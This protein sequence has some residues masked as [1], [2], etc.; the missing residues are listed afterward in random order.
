M[1]TEYPV[2]IDP[3]QRVLSIDGGPVRVK[4][5]VFDLLAF[6]AAHPDTLLTRDR[7]L[8]EVW[9]GT[10]VSD[11]SV[12][13]AVRSLRDVLGDDAA[14]PRYIETVRGH[15]YRF[16]GG[17]TIIEGQPPPAGARRRTSPRA[18]AAVLALAAIAAIAA[19]A[20]PWRGSPDFP[21]AS[22][23]AMPH[24]LPD[25]PSVAVLSF[26]PLAPDDRSALFAQGLSEDLTTSLAK[27][28]R[29]FVSARAASGQPDLAEMPPNRI[30][31]VLGVRY[32]LRGSV[33]ADAGTVRVSAQLI[34]AL[35]GQFVWTERYDGPAGDFLS[36]QDD[37]ALKV[38][39]S[40]QLELDPGESFRNTSDTSDLESWLASTE[41]YGA[42]LRFEQVS[43]AR[44]R[45]LWS[46]ALEHDPGR[47]VPHAGIAFTHYHDAWR[48]WSGDR[49][50]SI[51]QGLHHAKIA[52]ARAPDHPLGYQALGSLLVLTGDKEEGIALRRRAVEL[53]PNDY[54]AIGG[55]A[56]FLTGTGADGEAVA[57]F[58]RAVRLNPRPP[59]WLPM[60]FG[61]ALHLNGEAEEAATWLA[62]A[63]EMD[64]T[65]PHLHARL[66]LVLLDLGRT[67]EADS[68]LQKALRLDPGYSARDLKRSFW[69]DPALI[70]PRFEQLLSASGLPDT[71]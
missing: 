71:G 6:F 34:D 13:D 27:L 42:F 24:A 4:G 18:V 1:A 26:T 69:I 37:I 7:I 68:A 58:R 66:A 35:E 33:Q 29:L 47:A 30:A 10:H 19:Y 67:A 59:A 46:R 11:A 5:K 49:A 55:L 61:H 2:S 17:V 64:G 25:R 41:A 50:V 53:G 70:P 36:R 57:L 31:E 38:L 39:T 63:V 56:T 65:R 15:G 60:W 3:A 8:A 32:L 44:A 54:A 45:M 14:T 21:P 48:G 16:L 23:A 52:L 22:A 62:R 9:P 28:P 12:K 20:L 43:N 40:L 51:A